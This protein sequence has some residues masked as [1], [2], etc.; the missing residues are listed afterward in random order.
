MAFGKNAP[1]LPGG[2][3]YESILTRPSGDDPFGTRDLYAAYKIKC[4]ADAIGFG[5]SSTHPSRRQS[6]FL[7]YHI[8]MRMLGNVVLLTPQFRSP[9]VSESVLTDAVLLLASPNAEGAFAALCNAAIGLLD[10]Y[11]TFGSDNSAHN[12]VSFMKIH[13]GDLGAFLKAEKMG[14]ESHSPLLVQALAI[15]NAAFN[16]SGGKE[17][18]AEALLAG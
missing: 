18:V 9:P 7:F 11:L 13:N 1:F 12:E 5:R 2:S 15:Q 16:M 10:Q 3:V 17:K 6:R 4:A 14:K 8:I